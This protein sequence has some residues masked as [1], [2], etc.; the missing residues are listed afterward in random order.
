MHRIC[1]YLAVLFLL[2]VETVARGEE[3]RSPEGFSL[4]YSS[5]WLAVSKSTNSEE[6]PANVAEWLA[7]SKTDI[8]ASSVLLV[9]PSSGDFMEY[10]KVASTSYVP[11]NDYTMT[12][13]V[14]NS[15]EKFGARG[16]DADVWEARIRQVG[17]NKAMVLDY[18]ARSG[19]ANYP[20]HVRQYYFS[21]NKKSYVLTCTAKWESFSKYASAFEGIAASFKF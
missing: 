19:I 20:L 10:A 21:K 6:L 3:F 8:G 11:I 2:V 14:G 13:L 18:K 16:I 5:G 17:G 15:Q 12:N 7:K 4:S 1:A 9:H